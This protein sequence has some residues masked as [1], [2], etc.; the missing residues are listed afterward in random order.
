MRDL[1]WAGRWAGHEA[2]QQLDVLRAERGRC[3]GQGEHVQLGRFTRLLLLQYHS[4][5]TARVC[6]TAL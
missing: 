5:T 1:R 6:L 4:T 3:L 2:R